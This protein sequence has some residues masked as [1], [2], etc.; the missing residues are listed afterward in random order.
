MIYFITPGFIFVIV[1]NDLNL[2]SFIRFFL[3]L[4]VCNNIKKDNLSYIRILPCRENMQFVNYV[5]KFLNY[6]KK[7]Y[8]E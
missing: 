6:R 5:R 8:I 7:K 3:N 2:G 4:F 1:P